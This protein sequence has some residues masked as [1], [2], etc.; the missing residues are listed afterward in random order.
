MDLGGRGSIKKW[1]SYDVSVFLLEYTNRIGFV[2]ERDASFNIIRYTRNIGASRS[3]GV[4]SFLEIDLFNLAGRTAKWGNLVFY[5]SAAY[6][7]A[8]YTKAY[9]KDLEGNRMEFAPMWNIRPGLNFRY[10][11]FST[12]VQFSYVTKQYT[13]AKNTEK[14]AATSV[15]GVVPSYYV[16]D[17]SL[18]YSV[19]SIQLSTGINNF[20]NS[21]YFTRRAVSYP[22]PGIIPA[23]PR[24]FY[25]SLG[26][27]L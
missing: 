8:F 10:K 20:T 9:L 27:K 18:N 3:M 14:D 25:I 23:E 19:K 21:I 24:T 6:V 11:K 16:A 7:N 26:L 13:D 17:W 15:A 2:R 22:G 12:S 1:F 4:E 5:T